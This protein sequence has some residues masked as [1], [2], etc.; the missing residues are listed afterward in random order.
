MIFVTVLTE[1]EAPNEMEARDDEELH[2]TNLENEVEGSNN[3]AVP[4]KGI[5]HHGNDKSATKHS[6]NVASCVSMTAV[7]LL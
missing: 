4:G 6:F 1:G 2:A 5:N 7:L 3:T